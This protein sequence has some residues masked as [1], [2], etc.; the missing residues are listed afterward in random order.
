MRLVVSAFTE[1]LHMQYFGDFIRVL[2]RRD[3][4][5]Q[6]FC[7]VLWELHGRTTLFGLPGTFKWATTSFSSDGSSKMS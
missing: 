5:K 2:M 4:A 7:T 3:S 6:L 1:K